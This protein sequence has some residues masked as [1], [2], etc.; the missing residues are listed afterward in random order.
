MDLV[1]GRAE[2]PRPSAFFPIPQD[3]GTKGGMARFCDTRL[4]GH[5]ES[6]PFKRTAWIPAFAGMT[7]Q[8]RRSLRLLV[9]WLVMTRWSPAACRA[10]R[11]PRLVDTDVLFQS[12]PL[13]G[14][15]NCPGIVGEHYH[16]E[17]EHPD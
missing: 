5:H 9:T 8:M 4:L 7:G 17:H 12:C 3:W 6:R 11:N 2:G 15:I 16:V 10:Q 13:C 1:M 14:S